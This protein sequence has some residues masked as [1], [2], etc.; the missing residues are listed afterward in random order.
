MS[1]NVSIH[2]RPPGPVARAFMHSTARIQ[3]IMGPIGSGKTQSIFTKI[4]MLGGQQARSPIDGRRHFRICVVRDTYRRLWE[5]T[6]P[7][8]HKIVPKDACEWSGGFGDP[9]KALVTMALGENDVLELGL[10]FIAIGDQSAEDVMRGYEP[11]GLYLNEADLMA[12]DVLTHG[13]PRVGRYPSMQHGGPTWRG[14]LMDFNAPD[15]ESWVYKRIVEASETDHS[16]AF[17]R[18]PSAL[19]EGAENIANLP[20]GYYDEQIRGQPDWWVRRFIRNEFGF[21][22]DGRPVYPEWIDSEHVAPKPLRPVPGLALHIGLD[23]GLSPAAVFVQH[24]PGGQWRVY[25]E[26]VAEH[27]TGAMR[28]A[29]MLAQRLHERFPAHRVIHA[30]ADPSA[31]YGA[32]KD[33]GEK[34]WIEIIGA[35]AAID[36]AAAPTNALI[37]RLE[38]VRRPLSRKIDGLPGFLLSPNC[39]VLRKGFN[40]TY[41]YRKLNVPQIEQFKLEPDKNDASHPH[42]A[43][44]YALCG[45][46]ED[47]ETAERQRDLHNPADLPR[48]VADYDNDPLSVY[49]S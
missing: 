2:W 14:V 44:Q 11:T 7:S 22:R 47:Y 49:S 31:A 16:I 37:P 46:G 35:Q 20:E 32:D 3:A 38:A 42:D 25:D 15:T 5:T 34:S 18:Q 21:S 13:L 10:D 23:A 24:M 39:V 19:V 4:V 28:F 33:A 27:G 41:R 1:A 45:G 8:W 26:L 29:D 48:R 12:E 9:A 40:S 43:L 30:W 6:I 36:I 17:F